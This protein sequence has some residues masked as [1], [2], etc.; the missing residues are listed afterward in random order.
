MKKIRLSILMLLACI[1]R[2]SYAASPVGNDTMSDADIEI[3]AE[4]FPDEFLRSYILSQD[5]GRDGILTPEERAA[6]QHICITEQTVLQGHSDP[7][8]RSIGSLQGLELFGNLKTLKLRR[9][10]LREVDPQVLAGMQKLQHLDLSYNS[11]STLAMPRLSVDTLICDGNGL[12][13]LQLCGWPIRY[14]SCCDNKLRQLAGLDNVEQL[15]CA[16]NEI[17][18]IDFGNSEKDLEVLD[19]SANRLQ[20]LNLAPYTNLKDL[21]CN[22]NLLEQ[23]VLCRSNASKL[24]SLSVFHNRLSGQQADLFIQSLGRHRTTQQGE[25]AVYAVC[26]DAR[27]GNI[28]RADQ[29]DAARQNGFLLCYDDGTAYAGVDTE[30]GIAID[31]ENFPDEMFRRLVRGFDTDADGVFSAQEVQAVQS[32]HFRDPG[33][34]KESNPQRMALKSLR[35]VEFFTGLKELYC[36]LAELEELNVAPLSELEVLECA[37]NR[38]RHLNLSNNKALSVL[39]C[40]ANELASLD[41]S[42]NTELTTL[43]CDGNPLAAL[44]VTPLG[45]L[46]VLSCSRCGLGELDL[47][48]NVALKTLV[49]EGNRLQSLDL[50]QAPS[51]THL[52]CSENLLQLLDLRQNPD[53][54]NLQCQ[55]NWIRRI[56]LP[57]DKRFDDHCFIYNN[58]LSGPALDDF[59][60]HLHQFPSYIFQAYTIQFASN[61]T[62]REQNYADAAQVQA[63]RERGWTLLYL[64]GEEYTGLEARPDSAYR[65]FVE[66]GKTWRLAWYDAQA[67][68]TCDEPQHTET[69]LLQGDTLVGDQSCKRFY[70]IVEEGG[71]SRTSY[72]GA[73]YEQ[74]GQVFI[75][76]PGYG[77]AYALYDFSLPPGLFADFCSV[78]TDGKGYTTIFAAP[79]ISGPSTH[80]ES[81]TYKGVSIEMNRYADARRTGQSEVLTWLQGVGALGFYNGNPLFPDGQGYRLLSCSV[82]DEVL[83][84]DASLYPQDQAYQ[85]A[86]ELQFSSILPSPTAKRAGQTAPAGYYNPAEVFVRLPGMT[87]PCTATLSDTS[88]RVVYSHS[89]QADFVLALRADFSAFAPGEYLLAISGQGDNFKAPLSLRPNGIETVPEHS[90]PTD[91]S[92][93][94]SQGAGNRAQGIYDLQGRRLQQPPARGLYIQNGQLRMR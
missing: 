44:D 18:H 16:R 80:T 84:Y 40:G 13:E 81:Q 57:A 72:L 9:C 66:E 38:I 15:Y 78:S 42:Q 37:E 92:A 33:G 35:G 52:F 21:R 60:A 68:P 17:E 22:D 47:S 74:E 36:P 62:G 46:R 55:N 71:N 82:G 58:R 69:L 6:V 11:L 3:N 79:F 67:D 48:A 14:V 56:L 54:R 12:A 77:A 53:V 89:F 10:A 5:Y 93:A 43:S 32:I 87:G 50:T 90:L 73:V 49:C 85:S 23:L 19:C 25:L 30:R 28:F 65:P 4:S 7:S 41:L 27:V 88:G 63:A 29:V 26:R 39:S 83:Y 1:G 51:L 2:A 76:L 70:S 20:S 75:F 94:G 8:E 31:E 91:P 86:T 64:G 59:L 61:E 34:E 45:K 24:Q